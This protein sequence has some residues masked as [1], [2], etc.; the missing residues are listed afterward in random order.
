M[1]VVV[2]P[3]DSL[4]LPMAVLVAAVIE[5]AIDEPVIVVVAG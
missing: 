2:D 3:H 5:A 1:F 4:E